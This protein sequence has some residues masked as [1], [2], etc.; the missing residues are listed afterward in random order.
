MD[1]RKLQKI[2]KQM[3]IESEEIDAVKV[4]IE[5]H[6]KIITITN[7]EVMKV[8]VMGRDS[9]QITG[10]VTEEEKIREDDI[11][12]VMEQ[13]GKSRED[14]VMKLRE[15]NNDIARAIVELKEVEEE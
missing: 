14:V 6:D 15:L 2:M 7:P 11:R 3:N 9:F 4:T 5:T 1:P 10:N 8:K 12:L 13:T